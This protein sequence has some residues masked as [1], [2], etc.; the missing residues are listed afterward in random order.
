M[1][2]DVGREVPKGG[3][4]KNNDGSAQMHR[5]AYESKNKEKQ[6]KKE[7]IDKKE[8]KKV[9]DN[10]FKTADQVLDDFSKSKNCENITA[11]RATLA[12]PNV[13]QYCKDGA[14]AAVGVIIGTIGLGERYGLIVWS[15][16][17][18]I[19]VGISLTLY[20]RLKG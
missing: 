11:H 16:V 17:A 5:E 14:Q 10:K 1:S 2:R 6:D 12:G 13:E 15:G 3:G 19:A 20:A 9:G 8:V 7:V 4:D 18:L